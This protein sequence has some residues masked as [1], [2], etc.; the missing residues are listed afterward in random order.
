VSVD[1]LV[2]LL[3]NDYGS[4]FTS[5]VQKFQEGDTPANLA[6]ADAEAEFAA[7]T[8][9]EEADPGQHER[10]RRVREGKDFFMLHERNLHTAR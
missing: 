4:V 5:T 2:K 3:G 6:K 7:D 10:H 1:G 8:D 9:A